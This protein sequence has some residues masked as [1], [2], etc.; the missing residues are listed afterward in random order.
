MVETVQ[1][2]NCFSGQQAY[3]NCVD[4]LLRETLEGLMTRL[5]YL[6]IGVALLLAVIGAVTALFVSYDP[7]FQ[8]SSRPVTVIMSLAIALVAVTIGMVVGH[9]ANWREWDRLSFW[10]LVFLV[11]LAYLF[12]VP[13]LL[14]LPVA[15]YLLSHVAEVVLWYAIAII[16]TGL[17][18][19]IYF[20]TLTE[21]LDGDRDNTW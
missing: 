16:G 21:P 15:D 18:A 6:R 1:L 10:A 5:W 3:N 17:G 12:L 11:C 20:E 2:S 9:I 13:I 4:I 8:A 14:L 19:G 7:A